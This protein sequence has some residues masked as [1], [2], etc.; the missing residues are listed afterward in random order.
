M[1]IEKFYHKCGYSILEVKMLV[2]PVT[3]THL[4]DGDSPFLDG[5]NGQKKLNI[6]RQCPE[7]GATLRRD[8]LLTV[9]PEI[10]EEKGPTGYIAVL[11]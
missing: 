9:K 6:L 7:C 1:K 3:E 5:K 10:V 4:V 11:H 2:G 8:R